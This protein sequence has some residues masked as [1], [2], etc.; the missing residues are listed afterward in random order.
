MHKELHPWFIIWNIITRHLKHKDRF[1]IGAASQAG[2]ANSYRPRAPGLT[3]A[4]Q[5]PIILEFP[6]GTLL[7]LFC[8]FIKIILSIPDEEYFS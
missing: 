1:T 8:T 3:T 5:K 7:L 2:D 6:Y 4:F